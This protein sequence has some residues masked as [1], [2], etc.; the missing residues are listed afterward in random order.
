[1]ASRIKGITIEIGGDATGLEKALKGVN[2]TIRT[3]QTNLKDVNKLLKLDPKNTTLLAQK[4]KL[5]KESISA[6]KDKLNALKEAQVQAKQQLENGELGQ[7]KYDALQREIAE[8]ESELKRLEKEAASCTGKHAALGNVGEKMQK[9]GDAITG[10]GRKIMPVSGAV[11]ALGGISVKTAADFDTTMS[12]VAA[13]SGAT[14]EEF[15]QSCLRHSTIQVK[16][17]T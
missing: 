11:A 9:T 5:L 12:K 15:D 10:V 3:T 1:M 7:D 16:N 2:T 14:G 8:T 6:T 13:V 17:Q 4:Q